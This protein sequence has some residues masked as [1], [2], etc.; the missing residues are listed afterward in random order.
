MGFKTSFIFGHNAERASGFTENFWNSK[1]S[2]ADVVG[3][4]NGLAAKLKDVHGAQTALTMIRITKLGLPKLSR[5]IRT[6]NVPAAALTGNA[7]SDYPTSALLLV[8]TSNL[9]VE[10]RQWIKGIPDAQVAKGGRYVPTGDY[11]AAMTALF[12]ELTTAGN[13]WYQRVLDPA[14]VPH[15]VTALTPLGVITCPAH[16]MAASGNVRLSGFVTPPKV[17]GVWKYV[18]VDNDTIRI[19]GYV[20]LNTDVVFGI[21]RA[22]ELTYGVPGTISAARIEFAT[23]KRVGRP[24]GQLGGKRTKRRR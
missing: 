12:C 11:P 3:K 24:I 7:V 19:E 1:D 23:S 18:K 14:K 4:A 5:I 22:R 21:K 10:T 6:G 17:N 13:G 2:L 16:G 20:G 15:E 8:L 9:G